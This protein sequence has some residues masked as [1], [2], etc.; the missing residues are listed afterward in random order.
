MGWS[1]IVAV[2]YDQAVEAFDTQNPDVVITEILILDY[3]N[4]DGIKLV[5]EL[6]AK[7]SKK[8]KKVPIIIFSEMDKD[9]MFKK[10]LSSG[11][12]ACYSKN[13]LSLNSFITELQKHA[14]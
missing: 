3:K 1:C 9:E 13:E 4:R 10:A 8:D 2:S 12:T 11:A 14:T 5:S 6:R 7:E